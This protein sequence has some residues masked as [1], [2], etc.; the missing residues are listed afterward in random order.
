MFRLFYK[1]IKASPYISA[2]AFERFLDQTVPYLELQLAQKNFS[3]LDEIKNILD[4][5]KIN[6]NDM[7]FISSYDSDIK[8]SINLNIFPFHFLPYSTNGLVDGKYYRFNHLKNV[9][10]MLTDYKQINTMF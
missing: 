6:N 2:P 7:C 1:K 3:L 8:N 10:I 9:Y 4:F 5:K